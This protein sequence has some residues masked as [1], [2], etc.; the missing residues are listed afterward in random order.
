MK[1]VKLERFVIPYH[2]LEV[3]L[4]TYGIFQGSG[5]AKGITY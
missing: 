4:R 3:F 5:G 1:L 2:Q